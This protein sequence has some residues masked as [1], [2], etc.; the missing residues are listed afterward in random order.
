MPILTIIIYK[1]VNYITY[2]A[3]YGTNLNQNKMTA[4]EWYKQ[5]LNK[6]ELKYLNK[7]IDRKVYMD[8]KSQAFEQA[9]EMEKEQ[10]VDAFEH[11]AF[12]IDDGE[13]YYNKTF[14]SE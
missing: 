2:R 9:K 13:Q 5:E 4:V 7:I 3:L 11:F 14:K 10:I 1:K 12:N 8:L 6:I